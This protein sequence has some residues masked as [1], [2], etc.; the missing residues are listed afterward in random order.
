MIPSFPTTVAERMAEFCEHFEVEPCKLRY[1]R[2]ATDSILMT[3][4]LLNWHKANGASLDWICVG[5]VTPMMAAYRNEELR[6]SCERKALRH[7]TILEVK[8]LQAVLQAVL[9]EG[10]EVEPALELWKSECA[11][12]QEEVA[13]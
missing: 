2:R 5:S 13:E 7:L 4:E 6:R 1:S 3:D 10:L 11:K 12:R 8:A 9:D